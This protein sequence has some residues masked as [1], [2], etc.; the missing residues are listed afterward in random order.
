M[1]DMMHID[2]NGGGG[3]EGIDIAKALNSVVCTP[4]APYG[5]AS[6]PNPLRLRSKVRLSSLRRCRK[7]NKSLADD[8]SR[9][10]AARPVRAE[11]TFSNR[12]RLK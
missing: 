6:G 4:L 2:A 1:R 9:H 11:F 7:R 5:V 12:K 8:T 10:S 3:K